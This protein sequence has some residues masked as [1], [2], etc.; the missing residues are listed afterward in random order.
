MSYGSKHELRSLS[1]EEI[2]CKYT[3]NMKTTGRILTLHVHIERLLYYRRYFLCALELH[4]RSDRR[5]SRQDMH[6]SCSDTIIEWLR[7]CNDRMLL[8]IL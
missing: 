2:V 3:Y 1:N 4:E 8:G 5:A 7:S 6:Q